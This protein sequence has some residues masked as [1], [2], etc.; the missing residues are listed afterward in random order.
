MGFSVS[1]TYPSI[2]LKRA[3]ASNYSWN[4]NAALGL[5]LGLR[6]IPVKVHFILFVSTMVVGVGGGGVGVK[7]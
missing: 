2:W 5:R 3:M 4:G 1:A 6:V 7:R